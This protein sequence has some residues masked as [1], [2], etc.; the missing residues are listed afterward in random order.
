MGPEKVPDFKGTRVHQTPEPQ[1]PRGRDPA[2]PHPPPKPCYPH[3]G[4]HWRNGD[5][6]DPMVRVE[7]AG[8]P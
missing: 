6:A 2:Q 8:L 5:P 4:R 7:K 1:A 3:S